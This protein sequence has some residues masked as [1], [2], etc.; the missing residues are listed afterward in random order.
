MWN[1][2]LLLTILPTCSDLSSMPPTLQLV[3]IYVVLFQIFQ[4]IIHRLFV[5][6]FASKSHI[7]ISCNQKIGVCKI[8]NFVLWNCLNCD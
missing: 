3:D 6:V 8:E 7:N 5:W 4:N 1:C 2:P